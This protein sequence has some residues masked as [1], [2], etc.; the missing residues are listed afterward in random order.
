MR[1]IMFANK[2]KWLLCLAA[3]RRPHLTSSWEKALSSGHPRPLPWPIPTS[4]CCQLSRGAQWSESH[5]LR[6]LDRP[7]RPEGT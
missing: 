1:S 7:F 2:E 4:K 5:L 6:G 3:E